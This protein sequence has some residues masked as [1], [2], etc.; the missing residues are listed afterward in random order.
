M[1]HDTSAQQ[2]EPSPK[3]APPGFGKA[4]T[5]DPINA[6]IE[7]HRA[8]R[9]DLER[10]TK[11]INAA[12]NASRQAEEEA[13]AAF[14]AASDT[15][16]AA[17]ADLIATRPADLPGAVRLLR[18][19]STSPASE[20]LDDPQDL[21]RQLAAAV[22]A[23][24]TSDGPGGGVSAAGEASATVEPDPALSAVADFR[25]AWDALGEAVDAAGAVGAP[26][27]AAQI[28]DAEGE[29]YE[30]LKTVRPTTPE[31]FR[32]LAG[33]WAMVLAGERMGE[34]GLQH[35]DH[36][37][38]S[39]I[40]GAGACVPLATDAP[41]SPALAD[42]QRFGL[43]TG[44]GS[45]DWT[46]PPPGF[47]ASPAIEPFGFVIIEE[48]IRIELE[49]LR[50]I[51]VNELSRRTSPEAPADRIEL[52]RRILR[53]DALEKAV[54]G[55]GG[56][57]VGSDVAPKARAWDWQAETARNPGFVPFPSHAPTMLLALDEAIP[58]EAERLLKLAEAE[59]ERSRVALAGNSDPA[60]WPRVERDMRREMW[61]D[62]LALVAADLSDDDGAPDLVLSA[63]AASRRA[64]AEMAAFGTS[65]PGHRMTRAMLRREEVLSKAQR[66]TCDAV[67]ATVPTTR[68]G[69]LA[70]VDYV[71]FQVELH[72]S[73]TGII[74]SAPELFEEFLAPIAAAIAAE[75]PEIAS[76]TNVALVLGSEH[77]LTT[78]SVAQLA[79]LYG[80]LEPFEDL[81]GRAENAPCFWNEDRTD[82]TP[83]GD[84]IN[85][86]ADRLGRLV[87]A[88]AEEIG[89]RCPE[90]GDERIDRLNVLVRRAALLDGLTTDRALLTEALAACEG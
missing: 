23:V 63:I 6:A 35:A 17:W 43:P 1:T 57:S 66:E 70:L 64:E 78:L 25:A 61:M 15:D 9:E 53:L 62:A 77:D 75:R 5:P 54:R 33:A 10:T 88:I 71:R 39:L 36:A 79:R 28:E 38:D 45:I 82:R 24:E 58:R 18:Y 81:I 22:E 65:V 37:A 69:R 13:D 80:A 85:M 42:L 73:E 16:G 50:D 68:A 74:D 47:M 3:P 29:A 76:S 20:I 2:D 30:R 84:I 8:A 72:T 31:G 52:L 34:P 4:P 49:R 89:R 32:A 60:F 21:L 41:V 19:V 86:E 40:A 67:W 59:I 83:D 90:S 11:G 46:K 14:S 26:E 12:M 51:A 55:E 56:F 48:G 87:R 7:R 44:G 27:V